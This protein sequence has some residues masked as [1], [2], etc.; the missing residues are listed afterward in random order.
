MPDI[1][2]QIVAKPVGTLTRIARTELVAD[3]L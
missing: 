1:E 2:K 3:R